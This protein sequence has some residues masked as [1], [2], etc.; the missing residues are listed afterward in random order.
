MKPDKKAFYVKM[1]TIAIPVIVQNL[2]VNSLTFVD[3]LMIGQLGASA[4]AAVGLANQ[5]SFLI[6]LFFFGICSGSSIFLAQFFGA[7]NYQSIQK[8]MVLALLISTI[9]S[10]FFGILA[11]F[12]P[13][14]VMHIFTYDQLV[15]ELGCEYLRYIGLSFICLA[16]SGIFA[17]GLRATN[18]AKIPLQ[19]SL[20]SLLTDVVLN[21]FLIFGIGP[22][23]TWGVKGAAIATVISRIVEMFLLIFLTYKF[24]NPCAITSKAAFSLNKKFIFKIIPTC[25]P[26]VCNEFF[27]AVGMMIYKIAFSKLG[28]DVIAAVNVNESIGNLFF[29]AMFGVASSALIMIGQKI[30]EKDLAEARVYCRRFSILSFIIGLL[31]GFLQI[32]FAPQ[33]LKAFNI[34]EGIALTARRCLYVN[35]LL[36]PIKSFDTTLIVGIL[37]SGGDTKFS[38]F[39]ELLS[40]WLIGIP[41]AFLGCAILK[42]DIWYVYLLVSAEELTKGLIGLLRVKSGKWLK[43]LSAIH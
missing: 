14:Q 31:M 25:I 21:Y 18:L 37:R 39:D 4:I 35:A 8:L 12:F 10:L 16:F 7:K 38:M 20:I 34:S 30:G 36:Y 26:V 15:V 27:W 11:I 43:D 3:T 17:A 28:M 6:N 1:G 32:A 2:L 22:F 24:K 33:F 13:Q 41:L 9:G 40:V 29:V 19:V 23:P 5:V 42:W